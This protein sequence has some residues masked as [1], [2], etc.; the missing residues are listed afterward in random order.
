MTR[1]LCRLSLL[2]ALLPLAACDLLAGVFGGSEPIVDPAT[3]A[4]VPP[5]V[6]P[7]AL[8]GGV[9]VLEVVILALAT[10][11]LAPVARILTLAK[12]LITPILRAIIGR[13]SAPVPPAVEPK[14]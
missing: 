2:A 10:L 9:D 5:V 1:L 3:G 8:L 14:P 12:P 7:P 4:V 11:G 13:K 6:E